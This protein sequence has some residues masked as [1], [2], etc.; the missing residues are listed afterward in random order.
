MGVAERRRSCSFW[1][2]DPT[3]RPDMRGHFERQEQ[4]KWGHFER[5]EQMKNSINSTRAE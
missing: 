1:D 4:S 2:G 3:Y 5:Q